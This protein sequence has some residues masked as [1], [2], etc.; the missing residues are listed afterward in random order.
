MEGE[1]E[2]LVHGCLAGDREALERLGRMLREVEP[3]LHQLGL[4]PAAIDDLLADVRERLLVG[5]GEREPALRRYDGRGS[6]AGYVRA[7]AVRL[8]IDRVRAA[9]PTTDLDELGELAAFTTSV[10]A[11]LTKRAH[12]DVV[13][14]AFRRAWGEIP[15]HQRL[16]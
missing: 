11:E 12:A 15:E 16:L 9:R 4:A 7:I 13:R 8:A 1:D 14:A 3:R 6:L 5:D 2:R 10:E